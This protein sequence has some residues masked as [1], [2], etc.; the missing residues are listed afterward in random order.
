MDW[1]YTSNIILFLIAHSACSVLEQYSA[2]FDT[3]EETWQSLQARS[4]LALFTCDMLM[5][6]WWDWNFWFRLFQIWGNSFRRFISTG[7]VARRFHNCKVQHSVFDSS[8]AAESG[9]WV[10]SKRY[11]WLG[12]LPR[13]RQ[14]KVMDAD[15][16]FFKFWC[17]MKRKS[18][19]IHKYKQTRKWK[20]IP[21]SSEKVTDFCES[22][23]IWSA[24]FAADLPS[25]ATKPVVLV[26][27]NI[28]P[29][30]CAKQILQASGPYLTSSINQVLKLY[31]YRPSLIWI[32]DAFQHDML[33][34]QCSNPNAPKWAAS[35]WQ[36]SSWSKCHWSWLSLLQLHMTCLVSTVTSSQHVE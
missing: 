24:K 17:G 34:H 32:Q 36:F 5:N 33:L 27:I 7:H 8:Q 20:N 19:E 6:F 29:C 12:L 25:L 2:I 13:V 11:P 10:C 16:I 9:D 18:M 35:S 30:L 21:M 31:S 26:E 4:L 28:F 15:V 23:L 22:V 1:Q 14:L 3:H